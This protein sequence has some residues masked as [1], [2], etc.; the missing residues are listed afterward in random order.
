[1]VLG[2]VSLSPVMV[3]VGLAIVAA[4]LVAPATSEA[5]VELVVKSQ[6]LEL[7]LTMPV[8]A[9]EAAATVA[10]PMLQVPAA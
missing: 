10:L 9:V 7:Q 1:M 3:L 2:D 6:S 5:M 8:V 4:V